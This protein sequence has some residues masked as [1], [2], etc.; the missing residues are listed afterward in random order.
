[1]PTATTHRLF[2]QC[3]LGLEKLLEEELQTI[4]VEGKSVPG[5]VECRGDLET[6][7]AICLRSR[8]SE[9]VRV[10]LKE[11]RAKEFAELEHN[12]KAL[13][14]RAYLPAGT[15]VSVRVVCQKSR[16][17]HSGAVKE[18]VE[19]VLSEHVGW[20]PTAAGDAVQVVHARLDDDRVQISLDATGERLSRRGYRR[21]VER[22]SLRET[23]A[24]A[25]V[26]AVPGRAFQTESPVLWD[27]FCGA[28]TIAL[29]ALEMSHGRVAG[30]GRSFAFQTWRGHDAEELAEV[31]RR[32]VERDAGT[33]PAPGL[34]AILT[35]RAPGAITA[36]TENAK[37]ARMEAFCTFLE[38]DIQSVVSEVPTGAFV[39][40]NPPYGKRLEEAGAMKKLLRVLSARRDISPVVVLVGGAARE[41][42]P[43]DRVALF[44]TKNG[45]IPVSARLIRA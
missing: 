20:L 34:R 28:G 25:L 39:V 19:R 3:T 10:R 4:G 23:L 38:G 44:R 45:G 32:L 9:S 27:P 22:A 40:T 15:N 41:L 13:P 24:A 42:V 8:I 2:V 11:F 5:G 1:M 36:A 7:S 12:L 29:E 30:A 17:W 21:H 35:D 26:R 6:L 33:A 14:F 43:K 18:R 37:L 16:L 31:R